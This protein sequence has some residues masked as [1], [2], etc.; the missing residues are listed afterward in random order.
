ME[1]NQMNFHKEL[2]RLRKTAGMSQEELGEKLGVS[3]QT[4][5]KWEG[6]QAYPDMLNLLAISKHFGVTVDE[7]I[8]G[9]KK[10]EKPS[11]NDVEQVVVP[12][13]KPAS[14]A[15]HCEHRSKLEIKGVPLIHINYGLGDYR[16]K[17]I[18]AIG[19]ISTGILSIGLIAKGFLSIGVLSIGM[20]AI[21]ILS[22]GLFVLGCIGAGIIAV[23]GIAMGVMTLGGVA[24]G[25]VS[26][27]GC[28]LST[29]VSVGGV[30]MAPVSIGFIVKGDTVM[31]LKEMGEISRVTSESVKEL[32]NGHY[33]DM[34]AVLKEWA[35]LIFM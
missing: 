35:T 12:D 14:R 34:P 24:L 32:I 18:I 30:A 2:Q 21:G 29:H 4:I 33:P 13:E 1:N 23:A 5:S 17:G 10:E 25:V 6:A 27:G 20:L 8:S 19:N 26:I 22:L 28:A 9:A 31:V 15:F 16:A 7:L 11:E 3:R